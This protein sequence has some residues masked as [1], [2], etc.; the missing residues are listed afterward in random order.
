M[1]ADG[2]PGTA[3]VEPH[4]AFYGLWPKFADPVER[5]AGA[6]LRREQRTRHVCGWWTAGE[7]QGLRSA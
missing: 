6:P 5:G 2:D 4:A 3:A 7:P 1:A